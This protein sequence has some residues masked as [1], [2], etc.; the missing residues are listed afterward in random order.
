VPALAPPTGPTQPVAA[1]AA[2][3]ASRRAQ[4]APPR[5][6]AT[7]AGTAAAGGRRAS[8]PSAAPPPAHRRR[9]WAAPVALLLAAAAAGA[10]VAFA[11][12]GS[13][14][15][16]GSDAATTQ[17]ARPPASTAERG[18][19][20]GASTPATATQTQRTQTQTAPAGASGDD[21]V[22]LNDRGFERIQ[23]QDFAAAVPLLQRS[24]TAFREQ[25]R[26]G[27]AAYAYA[28]YNLGQALRRAGRPAEAIPYLE[29]RL[30]VSDFK[31][32]VVALELAAAR[33]DAGQPVSGG[34]QAKTTA[35]AKPKKDK[36]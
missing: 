31:R 5:T 16:G 8:A 29:E 36:D 11:V 17:A 6:A 33:Q 1:A 10:V 32:N 22:A 27:E 21:P 30:A 9:R 23:A 12:A 25:G 2:P 7:A 26:K 24:V 19:S 14:G 35:K 34:T 13:G 15:S 28:L 3:R 4:P 20:T 18:T